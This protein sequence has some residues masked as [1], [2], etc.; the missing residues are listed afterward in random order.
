MS[1]KL[2][3]ESHCGEV[4]HRIDA[5]H[6]RKRPHRERRSRPRTPPH[7]FEPRRLSGHAFFGDSGQARKS[8]QQTA[9]ASGVDDPAPFQGHIDFHGYHAGAGGWFLCGWISYPWAPGREPRRMT[10]ILADRAMIDCAYLAFHDRDEVRG[11]GIG[12]VFFCKAE[13]PSAA[14]LLA[15]IIDC[16]GP[17]HVIYPAKGAAPCGEAELAERLDG[18]LSGGEDEPQRRLPN[19]TFRAVRLEAGSVRTVLYVVPATKK[20]ATA[21]LLEQLRPVLQGLQAGQSPR[22]LSEVVTR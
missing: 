9:E 18:I 3:G 14:P 20:L 19:G 8:R 6:Q 7:P 15:A 4:R 1:L 13:H 5:I 12:F 2:T 16:G 21:K 11:R 22:T 10:A 17:P